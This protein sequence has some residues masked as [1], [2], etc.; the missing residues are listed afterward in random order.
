[1]ISKK[2]YNL[3]ILIISETG[4]D[5][6]TF[7]TW[8]SFYKNLP[9]SKVVLYCHRND[10][11]TFLYFQWC[12]RLKIPTIK[13]KI[14]NKNEKYYIN[15]LFALI[16]AEKKGLITYPVLIVKPF[17]MAIDNFNDYFIKKFETETFWLDESA[18]FLNNQTA[19]DIINKY[20]FEGFIPKESNEKICLDAK[21]SNEIYPLINYQKGCGKW[22]NKSKGC[23]F[24]SAGGL[25]TSELTANEARVINLWKKMV[26]LY[27]AVI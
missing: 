20:Y 4:M 24:S 19:E 27:Q 10:D 23:P 17:V 18:I 9:E 5:W 22:I 12:K 13:A 21:Y 7:A 11:F 16:T 25:M 1:M 6:Q 3:S 8:Y 14:F 26:A 15:W 2:G